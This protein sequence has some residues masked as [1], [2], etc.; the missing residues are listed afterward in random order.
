[1]LA[2]LRMMESRDKE[3]MVFDWDRAAELIRER[4]PEVARAGLKEDWEWTGGTIYQAGE[5]VAAEDT[6]TYLASPWA[7]PELDMDGDVVSCWRYASEV[8][9]WNPHTFWPESSLAI[10]TEEPAPPHIMD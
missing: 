7:E 5:P 3:P 6:Y 8:P 9:E 2:Y 4:Q 10:L 1:M